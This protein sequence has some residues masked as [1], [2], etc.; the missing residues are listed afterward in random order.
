MRKT[1]VL[2]SIP[3]VLVRGKVK[4]L[5]RGSFYF[6]RGYKIDEIPLQLTHFY[7]SCIRFKIL[8]WPGDDFIVDLKYP[9]LRIKTNGALISR[10]KR[11]HAPK[12]VYCPGTSNEK[13]NEIR[14]ENIRRISETKGYINLW[15]D[16][17]GKVPSIRFEE[18]PFDDLPLFINGS[19]KWTHLTS[20]LGA[21]L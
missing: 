2:N 20:V 13:K 17:L 4:S 15:Y 11:G 1:E 8:A 6:V 7:R 3:D 10:I 18:I 21:S 9:L 16:T 14:N 19:K 12:I 5:K